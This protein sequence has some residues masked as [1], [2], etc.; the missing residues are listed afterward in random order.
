MLKAQRM[1]ASAHSRCPRH[2]LSPRDARGMSVKVSASQRL[3][4]KSPPEQTNGPPGYP[5]DPF[6]TSD[7][8]DQ[9]SMEYPAPRTV[10]MTSCMLEKFSA[11]R[12]RPTWT[13]TV[14]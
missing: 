4:L 10:R 13:S 11:L 1:F 9:A 2:R 6:V 14:R 12:R 5:D 8:S 7:H 3:L